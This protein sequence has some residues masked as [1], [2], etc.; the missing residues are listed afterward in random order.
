M[1]NSDSNCS[2]V[3]RIQKEIGDCTDRFYVY[4]QYLLRKLRMFHI[5]PQQKYGSKCLLLH[6]STIL[7]QDLLL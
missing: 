4:Y 7:L 3:K 2:Y 1:H 6:V 5:N